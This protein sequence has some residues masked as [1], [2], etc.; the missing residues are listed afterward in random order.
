M[1]IGSDPDVGMC[2]YRKGQNV[3]N[4][5][6]RPNQQCLFSIDKRTKRIPLR[7]FVL[8]GQQFRI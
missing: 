5:L 6:V 7:L 4:P 8:T 3:C 2:E 1:E